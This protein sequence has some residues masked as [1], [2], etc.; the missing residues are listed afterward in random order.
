[1][2]G[3]ARKNDPTE[4]FS[5]FDAGTFGAAEGGVGLGESTRGA[6]TAQ[7]TRT[8]TANATKNA[9]ATNSDRLPRVG[10]INSIL[11]CRSPRHYTST[12]GG[13]RS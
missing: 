5:G 12:G 2:D 7:A 13:R 10:L 3:R 1:M 4:T 9:R 6:A 11:A 8:S